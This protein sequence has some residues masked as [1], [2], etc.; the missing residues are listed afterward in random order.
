L[1][2]VGGEH[3]A[4]SPRLLADPLPGHPLRRQQ[5]DPRALDHPHLRARRPHDPLELRTVRVADLD[6][7]MSRAG[8]E[9]PQAQ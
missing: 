7:N 9:E 1:T 4:S 5:H 8:P 2:T 3:P 6:P